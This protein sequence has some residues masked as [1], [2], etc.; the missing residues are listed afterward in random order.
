MASKP[1]RGESNA[2]MDELFGLL[3]KWIPYLISRGFDFA[4]AYE[5]REELKAKLIAWDEAGLEPT[6]DDIDAKIAQ[7]DANSKIIEGL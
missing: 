7:I 5:N 4:N 1:L 3:I 6:D 2:I